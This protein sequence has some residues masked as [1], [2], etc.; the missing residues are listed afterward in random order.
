MRFKIYTFILFFVCLTTGVV[1][2]TPPS[3]TDTIDLNFDT[4]ALPKRG[5]NFEKYYGSG[6]KLFATVPASY[7]GVN[8][9]ESAGG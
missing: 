1:G 5:L 6:Q 2:Q 3:V 4:I 9:Y 8:V 7:D